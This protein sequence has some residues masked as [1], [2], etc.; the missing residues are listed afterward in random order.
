MIVQLSSDAPLLV[1]ALA[2]AALVAHIGGASLGIASGFISLLA[3]KGGR[4]HRAA[5]NV[6]FV[7]MLA[8]SGVAALA[9]PLLP[10]R[11]SALMGVFVFYLVGTA[12]LVVKRPAG[13][14]GRL[15]T[16]AILVPLAVAAGDL[17]L[18]QL[19]AHMPHRLIDGEPSQLGYIV[20]A[21]AMGAAAADFSVIRR[22]GVSGP[23][24]T[25][26]H[27]WRM[28]LALFVAAGSAVGQPKVVALLPKDIRHS[29]LTLF[30]P[31]LVVLALMVFWLI[32]VRVPKRR[33]ATPP[34]LLAAT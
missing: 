23:S 27:L 26:R 20:A 1:R 11:F 30:A 9:A 13:T 31:A 28:C 33:R 7:A 6:F 18:A 12:W 32:R 22:G 14:I 21:V 29:A 19:G 3:R 34:Q 10:D 8:M 25:A 16:A 15:E 4:L 5:G 2:G 24:R 17:W